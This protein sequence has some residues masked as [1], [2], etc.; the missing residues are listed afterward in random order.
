MIAPP[1]TVP[2][3]NGLSRSGAPGR[4][5]AGVVGGE[6]RGAGPGAAAVLELVVPVL[7]REHDVRELLT[8]ALVCLDALSVPAAVAVVDRGSSDRTVEA[9][10]EV[11]AAF[12]VP[13]R[14]LGCSAPA[15]G[16]AVLRAVETSRARWVVV[17]AAGGLGAGTAGV[18]NHAVR[19]LGERRHI[20]CVASGGRNY[21]V[22][23]TSVAE[24]LF[25][26]EL[27][28]GPGFVPALRDVP[29]HAGLRMAAHASATRK[30]ATTDAPH[31][32]AAPQPA[33]GKKA[34]KAGAG[35]KAHEVAAQES[36]AQES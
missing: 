8:G 5:A 2:S 31:P 6:R 7:N 27:P 30:P 20:V 18:F 15:W 23:E 26:E 22:L 28:A 3:R 16:S 24:L 13:V 33:A 17:G 32:P 36:K 9:V 29:G 14:V 11:A 12:P 1:M 25:R 21:T 34:H 19:L 10:D 4:P 35:K